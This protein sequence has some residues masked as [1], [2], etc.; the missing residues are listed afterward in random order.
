MQFGVEPPPVAVR[1]QRHI[2]G[3][4]DVPSRCR[5]QDGEFT[6]RPHIG[7]NNWGGFNSSSCLP[8][9]TQISMSLEFF[10]FDYEFVF[11]FSGIHEDACSQWDEYLST[12]VKLLWI[13]PHLHDQDFQ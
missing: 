5:D 11:S 2:S 12:L 13:L 6:L 8:L 3:C 9:S 4:S 10:T 7:N 1:E